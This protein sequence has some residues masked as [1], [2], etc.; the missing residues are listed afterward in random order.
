MKKLDIYKLVTAILQL[1]GGLIL[2]GISVYY[3][4]S[5]QTVNFYAFL[6]IGIIFVVWAAYS[7]IKP[8]FK[9]KDDDGDSQA[10]P[11]GFL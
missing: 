6:I 9:K 8:L 5:G 2:T 3:Y 4:F 11:K 10:P 1:V 7:L